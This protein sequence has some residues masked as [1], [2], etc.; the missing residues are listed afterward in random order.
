MSQ[1][2]YIFSGHAIG[3]AARFHRLDDVE[4]LNH[5]IPT[6]G[7]SVLPVT[8]GVS[9]SQASHYCYEVDH[10]RRRCLL[11]VR[12]IETS[13]SGIKT[14]R[15]F[16]T[17]SEA[18]IESI[19]FVEKLRIDFIRAHVLA[20]REVNS[21]WTALSPPVITTKGNKIEGVHLGPVEAKIVLD[22]EPLCAGGGMEQLAAFYRS[23]TPEYRQ[24]FCWRFGVKPEDT[25]LPADP[26][27][28]QFSLVREITL[29]GPE[30]EIETIKVVGN[31]I[32]WD[33]FGKIFFGEVLVT[34]DDRR[35]TMVRLAMDSDACGGASA[36]E[37]ESNGSLGSG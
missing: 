25:E 19:E 32:D 31:T 23:Q 13:A 15:R 26:S 5:N 21:D 11:S 12:R 36:G 33:G 17:E 35:L 28:L 27:Y 6:L 22:E 9:K 10:P 3:A 34:K 20:S 2:R 8:G 24:L 7:A 4:N 29:I 16:E 37:A 1:K 18:E 14:G 30:K